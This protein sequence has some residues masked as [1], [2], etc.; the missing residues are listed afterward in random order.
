LDCAQNDNKVFGYAPKA[1]IY[2]HQ[3]PNNF[4]IPISNDRNGF[5]SG[6]GYLVIGNYL[7]FGICLPAG[8]Q[9][10]WDLNACLVSAMPG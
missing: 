10:Y 3:I 5:V 4:Q 8:R 7:E 9:G 6:F 2:K 1:P